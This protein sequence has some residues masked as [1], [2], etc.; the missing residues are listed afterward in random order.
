MLAVWL[1]C[2]LLLIAWL[3]TQL[4]VRSA[5]ARFPLRGEL[6]P[7]GSEA[8]APKLRCIEQKPAVVPASAVPIVLLHGAFGGAEDFEAT[9]MP[10]LAGKHR[11]IALDR[12]GHGW[13]DRL[14]GSVNTPAEQADA[15]HAALR[16]AG[17]ERADLVGFSYGGSVA[18]SLA[19]RHPAFVRR[20]VLIN[21]PS[22]GWGTGTSPIYWIAR[23]PV[24]G[25][26]L[27]HT[28]VTPLGSWMQSSSVQR[29]F[30]PASI[31]GSFEASPASLALSP[32]R[33]LTNAED[34]CVLDEF[35]AAQERRYPG[36]AADTLLI[37]APED[38]VVGYH[39]HS[40]RLESDAPHARLIPMEEA[41]HALL[42]TH[43]Q[44]VALEI[45]RFVSAGN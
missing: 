27:R 45:D 30:A 28:L 44:Q 7:C 24:L 31:P 37:A 13:S 43:P 17:L 15:I 18:L 14:R 5:E 35:L 39:I 1:G 26:L 36:L 19:L 29:A 12:P 20:L 40:K 21:T 25:P 3:W 23:W 6:L 22:Y 42:F 11:V 41:G 10:L 8:D 38:R 32:G 2:A 9:L 33:F 16:Q 4:A 34:L